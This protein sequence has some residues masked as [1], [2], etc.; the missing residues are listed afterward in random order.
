MASHH[1]RCI[2]CGVR[3]D[4]AVRLWR[5]GACRGL[6]VV[7]L[8]RP[9]ALSAIDSHRRGLWRYR[10]FLPVDDAAAIVTLGEGA[11]PVVRLDRW[12]AH[13]GLRE[14]YAK[15]EHL[16]P[17]GSFKDRGVAPLVARVRELGLE[18]IVEDSSGNAGA[19]TASYAARAGVACT[20]YV[21]AAA[22]R[23]KVTQIERAG[24]RVVPIA[25]NRAAVTSAALADVDATGA[26]YAG[27]NANPYFAEGMKTFAFEVL[28][29]F[30]ARLPTHLVFPVGGGSLYWGCF[31][32]LR[33]W[34][35]APSW[36]P[37]LHMVQPA[38][39]APLVAAHV[40]RSDEPL[41]VERR[42]SLAGGMEIERP[43]RGRLLLRALRESGGAA[44]AVEDAE[45]LSERRRLGALE[46]LDVEPT[47]AATFAGLVALV[48]QGF[49]RADESVLVAVTG[50]GLKD[51]SPRARRWMG[52]NSRGAVR[53]LR[54]RSPVPG[55]GSR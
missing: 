40:A 43:P 13:H 34:H 38:G 52:S 6:L 19:S 10:A 39:C 29:E 28:E 24:A 46:G 44:V 51:P 30:A 2:D 25:G 1:L 42:P 27:H 45:I 55:R 7:E 22:P 9:D 33:L 21:P 48:R 5:C 50:S 4:G 26:Y 14:V 53:K 23:N 16:N 32:G 20:I 18:R 37:R 49:V 8:P 41:A 54:A 36:L 35:P 15:L 17:T 12:A 11:T 47:S 3:F 31:E